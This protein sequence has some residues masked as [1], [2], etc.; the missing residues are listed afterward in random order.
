MKKSLK[1]KRLKVNPSPALLA[2]A[3]H[4]PGFSSGEPH[5]MPIYPALNLVFVHVPKTAGGAIE[6]LLEPYKAP[7]RKTTFNRLVAKLP[8]KRDIARAYIP[9]HATALYLR[10]RMGSKQWDA[11]ISFAV[12]RNPYDQAISAYEF[13][14]QNT[15]HHRH[16]RSVRMSFLNYVKAR[17]LGQSAFVCDQSGR[18]IIDQLIKFES[19]HADLDAFFADL[20]IKERLPR[21]GSRNTSDKKPRKSYLT[22][23]VISVINTKTRADFDNFGYEMMS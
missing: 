18:V 3:V 22:P 5:T 10:R 1:K 12:V 21:Q 17:D 13:E 4:P 16:S 15:R 8:I 6:E 11:Y 20:N 9:G 19:L 2:P 14:R 7:G 23:E